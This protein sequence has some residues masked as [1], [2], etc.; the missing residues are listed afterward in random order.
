MLK[1]L[2]KS[3]VVIYRSPPRRFITIPHN[4]SFGEKKKALVG[5]IDTFAETRKSPKRPSRHEPLLSLKPSMNKNKIITTPKTSLESNGE[6]R[7]S[8][9]NSFAEESEDVEI[10]NLTIQALAMEGNFVEAEKKLNRLT[11]F[12]MI[13]QVG[14]EVG[15]GG[16]DVGVVVVRVKA[17]SYVKRVNDIIFEYANRGLLGEAE[18]LFQEKFVVEGK[19]EMGIVK[20][21]PNITTINY[22]MKAVLKAHE[23]GHEF[24]WSKLM[25]YYNA[26]FSSSNSICLLFSCNREIRRLHCNV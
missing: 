23:H 14:G 4:A 17:G 26:Y 16:E 24:S 12:Y 6:F 2:I 18:R 5:N 7:K 10:M 25:Y 15:G 11:P 8:I 22:M 20:A 21:L 9:S 19:N 3:C 13:P 1:R